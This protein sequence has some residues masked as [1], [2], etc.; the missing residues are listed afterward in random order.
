MDGLVKKGVCMNVYAE[1]GK[2][3]RARARIHVNDNTYSG[4]LVT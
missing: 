3:E 1:E 2:K 4:M